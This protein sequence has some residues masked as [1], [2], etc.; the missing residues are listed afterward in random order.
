MIHAK[1]LSNNF[2]FVDRVLHYAKFQQQVNMVQ[3]D[4]LNLPS[5]AYEEDQQRRLLALSNPEYQI[6]CQANLCIS[7]SH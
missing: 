1:I 6:F 3:R 7:I 4:S 5:E 2:A